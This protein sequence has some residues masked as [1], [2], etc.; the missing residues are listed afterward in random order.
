[1]R[2]VVY[3]F[4]SGAGPTLIVAEILN[5]SGLDNTQ[6]HEMPEIQSASDKK[7]VMSETITLYLRIGESRARVTFGVVDNLAA[8]VLLGRTFIDRLKTSIDPTERKVVLHGFPQVLILMVHKADS[9]AERS[10]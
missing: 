2:P 10:T 3:T 5:R 8:L 6:H 7:L 1:M 9:E 4:D